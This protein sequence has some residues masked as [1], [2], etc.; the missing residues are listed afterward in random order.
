M[1]GNQQRSDGAH[2]AA[3]KA[4]GSRPLRPRRA[5][6]ARPAEHGRFDKGDGVDEANE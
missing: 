4:H 2:T 5:V 1:N 6:P 3:W